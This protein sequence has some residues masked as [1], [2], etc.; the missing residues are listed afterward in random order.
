MSDED[1]FFL[2]AEISKKFI[3]ETNYVF[4]I[5]LLY[6]LLSFPHPVTKEL[7]EQIQSNY[8]NTTGISNLEQ[9]SINYLNKFVQIN[10]DI[11]YVSCVSTSR[12]IL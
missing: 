8:L 10:S 1:G 4:F 3:F 12:D 6:N 9:F 2:E 7:I 11:I 5:N